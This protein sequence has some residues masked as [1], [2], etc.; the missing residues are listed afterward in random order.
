MHTFTFY[1][2]SGHNQFMNSKTLIVFHRC[3]GKSLGYP[4]NVLLTAQWAMQA[5]AKAIEY[6][7]AIGRDGDSF[8][9]FAIEPKLLKDASLD[10]N[11]LAWADVK[12]LNVGNDKF[13]EQSVTLLEDMLKNVPSE[14]VAHQIQIKGQHPATVQEV[15][16]RVQS[17]SNFIITAFDI[18]VIKDIKA[19]SAETRVGWLVKPAQEDGDEAGVDLT[20]KLQTQVDDLE[21]YS[22]KEITTILGTAAEN[23]VDVALLCGPRI[24]SKELVERVKSSGFEIGA[25]GVAANL[26]L[27]KRLVDLKIDRFTIDNPE[28]LI[29]N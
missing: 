19:S 12:K 15:L 28:Q 24:Q 14:K 1:S 7:V 10:I 22:D 27:A 5:G 4:P 6:D 13:G 18:N 23:N 3:G 16:K 25:W 20:A 2:V 21:E 26:E 29:L 11:N 17:V 9:V 8:Q